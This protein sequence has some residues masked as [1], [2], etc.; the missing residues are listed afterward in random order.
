MR[1]AS[2]GRALAW[3][4]ASADPE[5]L[6]LVDERAAR[7]LGRGQPDELLARLREQIKQDLPQGR[8]TLQTVAAALGASM[9][10]LQRRLDAQNTNFNALLEEVSLQLAKEY[11]ANPRFSAKEVAFM[12]GYA[13]LSTFIRAFKR[14]TGQTPVEFREGLE[15]GRGA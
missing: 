15:P 13:D 14:A 2:R 5:L 9:R 1:C 8:P 10:T 7:L 3:P 4:L 12:V 11:L 6:A